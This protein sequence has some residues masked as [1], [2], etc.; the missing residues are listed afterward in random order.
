MEERPMADTSS[1]SIQLYTLR[2]LGEVDTVLDAAAAAGYRHVELVGSHLDDAEGTRR[3]LAARDLSVSSSHVS[4][5]ALRENPGAILDAC[6][7]LGFTTLFMPSVPPPERQSGGDYWR[8]LGAELGGLAE[9][10]RGE[11]IELGYHNH[12]WELAPKE[13]G[14]TALELLFEAAGGSPLTW[15]VDVAWLVR[16]GADPEEWMA[17]YTDRVS[18]AHVK[19]LAPEGQNQDEDGW[20][21]VGAGRLDWPRLWQACRRHGARWMVVEHDKPA[22]P[23]ASARNSFR[24]ISEMKE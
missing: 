15:Q 17:R 12:N 4:I 18:A 2:M 5:A 9:R 3:K 13:D 19:D 6:R 1:L 7:V 8:A 20:A 21:D 23:A 16:G 24:Y 14:R 22:D 11:G 10:F